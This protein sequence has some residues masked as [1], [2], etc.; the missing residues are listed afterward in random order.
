MLCDVKMSFANKVCTSER[1][2]FYL[3]EKSFF[4]NTLIYYKGKEFTNTSLY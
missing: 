2:E 4:R 3:L 1:T